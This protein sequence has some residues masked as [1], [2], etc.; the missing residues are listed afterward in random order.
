MSEPTTFRSDPQANPNGTHCLGY[1]DASY[2][3]LRALL[4]APMD[5]DHKVSTEWKLSGPG[6]CVVTLYDYKATNLYDNSLPT[7]RGFR[8]MK[9][10]EWHIG[11]HDQASADA[12]LAW[13]RVTLKR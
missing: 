5:G 7:V 9:S 10:Y 11:A 2:R 3:E 8:R 12:L 6:G 1:F 13:L 4:G